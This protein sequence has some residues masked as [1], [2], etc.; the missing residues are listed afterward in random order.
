M[1][2]IFNGLRK[3]DFG[4]IGIGAMI[5]F[6]AMVLVAGIA[7]SVLIQTST[8][9]ESQAMQT[10][11]ETTAEVATGLSVVDVTGKKGDSGIANVAITVRARAGSDDIDINE[12][13]LIISDGTTKSLLTYHGWSDG[14]HFNDSV[15]ASGQL[16]ENIAS[17]NGTLGWDNLTNSEFGLVVL[18]D[19]DS[20]CTQSNPVINSGDKVVICIRTD[21]GALFNSEIGTRTDVYGRV[22]PEVGSPGI[23]SFTSP[24][25]YSADTIFDLQ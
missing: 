1:R 23:V 25:S 18:N 17:G 10:G 13:V 7:A 9:L 22:I 8:K 19:Y 20:S 12:T 21:T 5:V 11:S 6:I 16:F 15:N 2:K 4:A 24:A 3:K 14:S